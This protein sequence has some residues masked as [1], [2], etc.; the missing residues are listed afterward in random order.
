MK[1][2]MSQIQNSVESLCSRLDQMEDKTSG[3][4][5]KVDVVEKS[6]KDKGKI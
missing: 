6:D 1:S 3:L 4:E 2:S 5:Y